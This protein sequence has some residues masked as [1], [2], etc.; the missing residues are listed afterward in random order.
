MLVERFACSIERMQSRQAIRI[1]FFRF[2]T[3]AGKRGAKPHLGH[4]TWCFASLL[5]NLVT[6]GI[7]AVMAELGVRM[8]GLNCI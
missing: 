3:G 4:D 2:R 5:H 7:I 6:V 8:I 1:V